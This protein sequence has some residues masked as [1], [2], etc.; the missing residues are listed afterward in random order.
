MAYYPFNG[1]TLDASGNGNH[2]INNNATLTADYYGAPD[3]AYYFNGIDNFMRVPNAPSLNSSNELSLCVWIKP[4]GFYKG[5]CHSNRIIMKGDVDYV[6]GNYT[7]AFDDVVYT[8]SN[9]CLIPEVDTLHQ[10]FRALGVVTPATGADTPFVQKNVWRSLVFTYNGTTAKLYVDCDIAL[11]AHI[12]GL[13]FV[14]AADLFLGKM[15]NSQ[16]P[17][18]Y[19][20]IMDEVRIY[21]RA[22]NEQEVRAY[23]FACKDVLP[24]SNWL[25]VETKG[26]AVQIG[27]VDVAGDQMTIEVTFNKIFSTGTE[28][29]GGDLVSKHSD[30]SDCN[31]V[32]RPNNAEITT[33]NG[34]FSVHASCG[35]SLNKTYHTA[36]V[37][38]GKTL[39]FFQNGFLLNEVAATG[40]LVLNDL[41]A[42]IGDCASALLPVPENMTGYIN[43]VRIWNNARSQQQLRQFMNVALPN[44]ATQHGLIA[45]YT[46]E[47]L[48]NK[49]GKAERDG[50]L[51]GNASIN[52]VNPQ[53]SSFLIDSCGVIPAAQQV[54][55]G[56]IAPDTVCGKAPVTITNT[57]V[58]ATSYSWNFCVADI[59]TTPTAV[60]L[61]NIDNKLALPVFMDFVQYN[62][63]YYGFIINHAAGELIRLNFGSSL[64]NTPTAVNLGNINGVIPNLAEGIQV[65]NNEGKWYALIVGG[66]STVP[67]GS[68]IVK[69]EFGADL[70]NPSPAGISWGNIGGINYPGDL[71]L[72]KDGNNWYG[73]TFNIDNSITRIAFGSSFENTPTAQNLGI[74]SD[75]NGPTG[76]FAINDNGKWC[77]FVINRDNSTITRLDFGGSLLNTPSSTNLGNPGNLFNLPR[78]IY[79]I[80]FCG[81]ITGF[82]VNEGAN[83]I[84]KLN[85]SDLNSVPS[86]T[87]LGNIGNFSFP[88]SI[89]KIFRVGSD[90]YSF[91]TNVNNNSLSRLRFTGCSNSSI[92][93]STDATPPAITYNTPGVYNIS[94]M[95]D[96]GL[97]TQNSFCKQVVVLPQPSVDFSFEPDICNPAVVQFKEKTTNATSLFWDLGNGMKINNN[98]APVTTYTTSGTYPVK[99]KAVGSGGCADSVTKQLPVQL[100][101]DSAIITRD[102]TICFKGHSFNLKAIQ[103]F[104]YCWSPAAGLSDP[105]IASP[106][107]T[108][109]IPTTT[110]YLVAKT[111][112][113]NL[114][115]NGDF[116]GGNTGFLSDYRHSPGSGIDAGVYAVRPDVPGWH[117]NM[118]ACGDHTDGRGNMMLVNG[119]Q[120]PNENV[121]SKV[122]NVAPNTNYAFSTW[123]QTLVPLNSAQLQFSI[124]GVQLGNIFTANSQTCIWE[125]FYTV[126]N[127]GNNTTATISI[128]NKNLAA[129]GNDFALDDISFAELKIIKDSVTVT[130]NASPEVDYNYTIPFCKS[131]RLEGISIAEPNLINKWEWDLG[132]N[133]SLSAKSLSHSY[134][135]GGT[136]NVKLVATDVKGCK[137]SVVKTIR[138]DTVKAR[139][140]ADTM[141]CPNG[142]AT[143]QAAGGNLCNWSYHPALQQDFSSWN[144]TVTVSSASR[145]YV[146]VTDN[147]QCEDTASILVSII[148]KPAF[149]S[150]PDQQTCKGFPIQLNSNNPDNTYKFNWSPASSLNDG[151]TANPISSTNTSTTYTLKITEPV[152][153]YDTTFRVNLLVTP[154]E[155]FIL[156]NAFTPNNDGINDCFGISRWGNVIIREFTIYNRWGN[157]VFTTKDPDNCWDGSYKGQPQDNGQYMYIIRAKTVCGELTRKGFLMLIR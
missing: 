100:L 92:A 13:S 35:V 80:K 137:D 34:H 99:L 71:Y 142:T 11:E 90:V 114:I 113:T 129:G 56:F 82:V 69:I 57:S 32:L 101:I 16:Y 42:T 31:Y 148:P 59:N 104:S 41:P 150:P 64:L 156:P 83:D 3:R 95:I 105:T 8:N 88:H 154:G 2:A 103:A 33:S 36:M 30:I 111:A 78:D 39:K 151:E 47:D 132:D 125:Q 29:A 70:T 76:I 117:S 12:P 58:N 9:T 127:S 130:V 84:I 157:K 145:F 15:N 152:C 5:A 18:W 153:G 40:N 14:N 93:S 1:N 48:K 25:K 134:V 155:T 45:C 53:C 124:N 65:V 140:S 126:W 118:T 43:N 66:N 98:A 86:A 128:I 61:G 27:D 22:L 115:P 97:P 139:I 51:T 87:S 102:T 72:F 136:Y 138:L 107:I 10:T 24:C 96:E 143:L 75:V 73:I 106:A 147:L 49:Q 74:F 123:L 108:S 60:N 110:Y 112:G 37:Y 94:L 146:K 44:P 81:Q 121:W 116:S 17:Y 85:F 77:V 23:S 63:N 141:I 120:T 135:E 26:D 79:I 144:Q 52:N 28:F 149:A 89:S 7:L 109:P 46:F 55:A 54:T 19:N 21:N 67:G 20:G 50:S 133:T 68:R 62:N 91:V 131:P 4:M 38:D 122:I 6:P 119:S